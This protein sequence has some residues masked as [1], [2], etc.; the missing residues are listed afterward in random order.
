MMK[1]TQRRLLSVFL[2]LFFIGTASSYAQ[3]T[4]SFSNESLANRL[5]NIIK[6]GNVTI[7]YDVN[8]TK[9][10][11]LPTYRSTDNNPESWLRQS[12]KGTKFSYKKL[13]NTYYSVVLKSEPKIVTVTDTVRKTVKAKPSVMGTLAGRVMDETGETLIG[14]GVRVLDKEYGT[15]TGLDGDYSFE[16]P[17]GTYTVEVS[18]ISYQTSQIT[19]VVIKEREV[20]P[21]N[22]VM[23]QEGK[24]LQEV[25]VTANYNRSSAAGSIQIQKLAPQVSA[26]LSSEQ[27]SKTPDK[28]VQE[29]LKRVTGVTLVDGKNV[30]VRGMS[31]RWNS[32][33]LDGV[34]LPSTDVASKGFSFDL[35][36]SSLIENIM[37]SK[38]ITPDMNTTFA[39]G[40]VQVFTHD[41]P[42]A[43]FFSITVGGGVNDQSTFKQMWM[44]KR[45]KLDYFGFDDGRRAFP[46]GDEFDYHVFGDKFK[47]NPEPFI[48]EQ[49]KLFKY[50]LVTPYKYTSMPNSNAQLTW[51][52]VFRTENAGKL[53]FVTAVSFRNTQAA[54]SVLS[55]TRG[56]WHTRTFT[57]LD[58]LLNAP[59]NKRNR[60][61]NDKFSTI[62]SGILNV[63]WEYGK[64]HLGFRNIYVRKF[65]NTYSSLRGINEELGSGGGNDDTYINYASPMFQDLIQSKL[66]GKHRF[67]IFGLDWTLS[68]TYANRRYAGVGRTLWVEK[69]DTGFPYWSWG[70]GGPMRRDQL[71]NY[72][73]HHQNY[74][75]MLQ[76]EVA[77]SVNFNIGPVKNQFKTGGM[78]NGKDG[79]FSFREVTLGVPGRNSLDPRYRYLSFQDAMH[80]DHMHPG[81][82]FAFYSWIPG[83]SGELPQFHGRTDE[84][85]FF[86]ML[87]HKWSILRLVWGARFINYRYT[88]FV[89]EE[90][91]GLNTRIH[92]KDVLPEE[93]WTVIP[94]ANL[95]VSPLKWMDFRLSYSQSVLRP[96]LQERL[97]FHFYDPVF[98]AYRA[99]A[100]NLKSTHITAYDARIDIYPGAGEIISMGGFYRFLEDP[101][102]LV[103]RS[104]AGH[105][106]YLLENTNWA[107]NWGYEFEVRKNFEF[108]APALKDFW[109]SGNLSLILSKVENYYDAFTDL[110]GK[111]HMQA[112]ILKRPLYGQTPYIYNIGLMYDGPS[113]GA[114]V[115]YNASGRRMLYFSYQGI[116]QTEYQDKDSKLDAQLSYRFKKPNINIK[117]NM[118]NLLS[119]Y[120]IY[121]RN[122][123]DYDLERIQTHTP[124]GYPYMK[125][126]LVPNKKNPDYRDDDDYL[127]Y[128]TRPGR[129]FSISISWDL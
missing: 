40:Y 120:T 107:K 55:I 46:S 85:A 47:Y 17:V 22:V 116:S 112:R 81:G 76:G 95:T 30:S 129:T 72:V 123:G 56:N 121:Y 4:T 87:E 21:L 15:I 35:I 117:L 79:Q 106:A 23:T 84:T 24:Q 90:V 125:V 68:H 41:I 86:A 110:Q 31:E 88:N 60:G 83:P 2:L 70:M 108:I 64:H 69:F 80:P 124:E 13:G 114:N 128:V 32:A 92:Q 7:V 73:G 26:V 5:E 50:D 75:R 19:D 58:T 61:K 29:A 99:G 39:G 16:L 8:Q 33:S 38:S 49:S 11:S 94:S 113:F 6:K 9:G 77:G 126:D 62:L 67:G 65:D 34:V 18:Y 66:E 20:T 118:S 52:K 111:V 3:Q 103:E 127:T 105:T 59:E 63:G 57:Q 82:G 89:N 12:L 100:D 101:I 91:Q 122:M 71:G 51:G 97:Q 102:E 98:G 53:G 28:N 36:P 44:P 109:V 104:Y 1:R 42:Q 119:P 25:T 10:I 43:D 45:G 14:A 96:E 115:V 74:E 37:V 54:D 27:I 78:I 48:Y 93:P